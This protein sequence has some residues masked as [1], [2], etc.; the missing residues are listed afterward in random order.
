MV[1]SGA[2]EPTSDTV[3]LS[4]VDFALQHDGRTYAGAG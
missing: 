3:P 1:V 2:H 4:C